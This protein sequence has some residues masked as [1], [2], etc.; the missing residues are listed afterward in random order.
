MKDGYVSIKFRDGKISGI[1]INTNL[2]T[3]YERMFNTAK[4]N[5]KRYTN[6]ENGIKIIVFGCFWLEATCNKLLRELIFSQVDA[7]EFAKELWDTLKRGN[8]QEKLQK[9]VIF[10]NDEQRKKLSKLTSKI[11]SLFELR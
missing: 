4:R 5:I 7:D 6:I 11:K 8:F 3:I 2:D 1:F 10:A 9:L